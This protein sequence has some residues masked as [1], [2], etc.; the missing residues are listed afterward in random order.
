MNRTI[1]EVKIFWSSLT[2]ASICLVLCQVF[3]IVILQPWHFV[4]SIQLIHV[5]II[6]EYTFPL[7]V[8]F[9][10]SPLFAVE[11]G[12]ETSGW[13]MSLPYRSSLFFVVRW[14]LGLCMVGILF[15]GSILVIHLWVIPLPLL[16][17]SIHVLP[18]ALWLG[19]LAL[20]ISLIGRSYVA[21]LGAALFYWVVESL[22]NGAITKK[23]SLFSSN[24]SSD[25]NFISNRTLFMLSGFVAI[26]LAL[27]LFCRRHFYSGRA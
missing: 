2:I 17:F 19:H 26:I 23:F 18:P 24:V 22:T 8:V 4:T 27:M 3:A 9:L 21:G 13:F 12:K 16:S 14:L 15:L 1:L 25:P 7:V 5:Q 11:I 10:M 6:Y 20:L